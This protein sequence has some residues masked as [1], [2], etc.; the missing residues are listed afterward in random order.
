MMTT[1]NKATGS[2]EPTQAP[3]PREAEQSEGEVVYDAIRGKFVTVDDYF[4]ISGR[5]ILGIPSVW[6]AV[7]FLAGTLA[8]LPLRV[9]NS[10][11]QTQVTTTKEAMILAEQPAPYQTSFDWRYHVWKN[12]FTHGRAYTYISRDGSGRLRRLYWDI[13]PSRVTPQVDKRGDISYVYQD[14]DGQKTWSGDRV[15]DLSWAKAADGLDHISPYQA[16][17]K[18]FEMAVNFEK[19]QNKFAKT[20]GV[21]PFVLKARWGSKTAIKEGLKDFLSAVRLANKRNDLVV[22]IGKDMEVGTLGVSPEQGRVLE[23]QQFI[24]RQVCRIFGIPPIYL[25]DLDRMTFANAEHQALNLTKYTITRWATQ[26]EQQVD[27]KILGP[28]R[29]SRHDMDSLLRGDYQSRVSGHSTA[30]FSGQLT[31]NEARRAE[32]RT[33]HDNGDDLYIQSATVPIDMLRKQMEAQVQQGNPQPDGG[34]DAE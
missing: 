21:P 27:L 32:D 3:E 30:I 1:W 2:F 9:Y 6:A 15:L 20:G 19:Y 31:P 14:K 11:N 34:D 7:D 18:T 29:I 16:H 10:S 26:L 33:P 28:G 22:P 4:V 13:D 24:V 8:S 25:H 17:S 23:T 12:L 5:S